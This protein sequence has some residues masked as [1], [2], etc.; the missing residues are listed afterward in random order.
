[1]PIKPVQTAIDHTGE[2]TSGEPHWAVGCQLRGA[3]PVMEGRHIG[4]GLFLDPRHSSREAF[5]GH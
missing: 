4:A 3:G 1:M 2:E 5:R